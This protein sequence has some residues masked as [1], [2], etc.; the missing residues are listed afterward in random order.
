MKNFLILSALAISSLAVV[1]A[2]PAAAQTAANLSAVPSRAGMAQLGDPYVPPHVKAAARTAVAAPAVAR[3]S[4]QTQALQKLQAKF[5]E[6]DTDSVGSVTKA[7]A[8][9]A[10]F[11]FVANNFEQ[12]DAGHTGRVTFENV[13]SF[14]R[15]NGASF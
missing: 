11:G 1:Q 7:Q 3:G 12:I 6:A 5:N 8:Q 15:S 14:M 2:N 4:L 9:K 13:K 10:G